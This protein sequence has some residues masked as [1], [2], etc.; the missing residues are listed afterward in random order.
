[1]Y[2]N[3][4]HKLSES[5]IDKRLGINEEEDHMV[6]RKPKEPWKADPDSKPPDLSKFH[7]KV[8]TAVGYLN[9]ILSQH[10]GQGPDDMDPHINH[11]NFLVRTSQGLSKTPTNSEVADAAVEAAT[12]HHGWDINR[13]LD[14]D[15]T[16]RTGSRGFSDDNLRE[17]LTDKVGYHLDQHHPEEDESKPKSTNESTNLFEQLNDAKEYAYILEHVLNTLLEHEIINKEMIM[18]VLSSGETYDDTIRRGLGTAEALRR[19]RIRANRLNKIKEL[20][21]QSYYQIPSDEDG[22]EDE[23]TPE[24]ARWL[25]AATLDAGSDASSPLVTRSVNPNKVGPVIDAKANENLMSP[26][27]K[28]KKASIA[29]QMQDNRVKSKAF[30]AKVKKRARR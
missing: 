20:E 27:S 30:V 8:V 12:S 5:Y 14:S 24:Y 3:W 11:S 19:T 7:P 15:G 6:I 25:H 10:G 16:Y 29:R 18:E 21:R 1:M 23:T 4:I 13:E 22:M 28:R 17:L 26:L 9:K 2:D